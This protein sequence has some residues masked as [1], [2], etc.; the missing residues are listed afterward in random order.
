MSSEALTYENIKITPFDQ[1]RLEQF[2]IEQMVNE[3]GKISL[4]GTITKEQHDEYMQSVQSLTPVNVL[5]VMSNGNSKKLFC[6][7]I[8]MLEMRKVQDVYY[9]QAEAHTYSY[10]LDLKRN[11]RS[12]QN[13]SLNYNAL[14][15]EVGK[16]HK[17][18]DVI[19][20]VG[21]DD[22][23]GK[24]V[25]QYYETDWTFL[26]RMAAR[27]NTVLL[28]AAH[29]DS[30]KIYFGVPDDDTD[31]HLENYNYVVRKDLSSY[32]YQSRNSQ[33]PVH[34]SD[35]VHYEVTTHRVLNLGDVIRFKGRPYCIQRCTSSME[36][37]LLVHRYTITSRKGMNKAAL[38][39][40]SMR[41][42]SIGGRVLAIQ[43]D[44]V[45]VHL[46]IDE[47]GQEST[48]YS[49]PYATSYASEDGSGWY[50][51]PEKGDSVRVHFP[52]SRETEAYAI[53][54]VNTYSEETALSQPVAVG[55]GNQGGAMLAA[56]SS[57][58]S[59]ASS[60]GDR[61]SD[62][63][64]RYFRN[65]AGMEVKLTP[66]NVQISANNGQSI[67]MLEANG[68]VTIMGQKE[69]SLHSQENVRIRAEK[70]LLLTAQDQIV[71]SS[72]KGG[73]I[74]LDESGNATMAGTEVF[75]NS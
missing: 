73:K 18:Y 68:A 50:C 11:T 47:Q 44:T 15:K 45:K 31:E 52:S 19:Y 25:L 12:F 54:S 34:E 36:K 5:Q 69:V 35:F 17:G 38:Y 2:S 26:K 33:S 16:A 60:S 13:P 1:M 42:A 51:M 63:N 10:M 75:T 20:A 71:I 27:M 62:P 64:V 53:S 49:F 37:G 32:L 28:P 29:L 57:G 4:S 22:S 66:D 21:R 41:G 46:E 48:A 67:I 9:L 56:G 72:D 61:M 70:T 6:G 7:L 58:G 65:P 30:V 74:T 3:H 55:T 24:F 40:D 43:R 14:A 39:N 23:I 8:T 59:S